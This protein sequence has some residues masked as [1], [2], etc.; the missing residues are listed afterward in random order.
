MMVLPTALDDDALIHVMECTYAKEI[1]LPKEPVAMLGLQSRLYLLKNENFI[2][3]QQ[4]FSSHEEIIIQLSNMGEHISQVEQLNTLL[5]V[6]PE[7]LNYLLGALSVL[8]KDDLMRMSLQLVKRIF[9][10]EDQKSADSP[11][12]K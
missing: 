10:D 6:I 8:R 2:S 11:N 4:L 9:L 12:S 5:V 3:L 1:Y 7:K